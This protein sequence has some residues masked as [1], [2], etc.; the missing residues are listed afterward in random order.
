MRIGSWPAE[1]R[2]SLYAARRNLGHL[3]ETCGDLDYLVFGG[4]GAG[5]QPTM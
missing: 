2:R 3:H 1:P 4:L 5:N